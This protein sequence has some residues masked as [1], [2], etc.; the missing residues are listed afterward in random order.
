MSVA[1]SYRA[2]LASLFECDLDAIPQFDG[3]A[4]DLEFQAWLAREV[5]MVVVRLDDMTPPA[6]YWI[7]RVTSP[8]PAYKLHSV[9]MA[10]ANMALDPH[11]EP[12][13]LG[14]PDCV[15]QC[16]V[17]VPLDPAEPSGGLLLP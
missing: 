10:G 1:D 12:Q 17:F 4:A 6:C 14:W 9:V 15:V 16:E 7:A 5:R 3:L 11:P 2:C 13:H 8:Y